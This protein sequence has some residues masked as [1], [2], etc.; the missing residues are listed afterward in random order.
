MRL[1]T[2]RFKNLNSLAGEWQIDFTHTD[3]Q[4]QG[5][6]AIVGATGAGKSTLLDAICL[7]LY[8]QTPRL[9]KITQSSNEIMS[10]HYGECFAEVEFSTLK[11]NYRCHWG[12][13]RAGKKA[14]GK[15]QS[16][17]HEIVAVATGKVLAHKIKTVQETLIEVSGLDFERFTRAILLAQ[18]GFSAFLQAK[19]DERSPIL[20]QLTGTK[21][22]SQI[23]IKVAERRSEAAK[24]LKILET[25][26]AGIQVLSNE[27]EQTKQDQLSASQTQ[28]SHC[29]HQREHLAKAIAWQN[30][31][32]NNR[33]K[34]ARILKDTQQ[35]ADNYQQHK[36][37]LKTLKLAETAYAIQADYK[38][39]NEQRSTLKKDKNTDMTLSA[40]RRSLEDNNQKDKQQRD[41]AKQSHQQRKKQQAD[42][43]PILK[44]VR[45]L[46]TQHQSLLNQSEQ[47]Q[48]QYNQVK[49]H[50][51]KNK[52]KQGDQQ[53]QQSANRAEWKLI[54]DYLEK[55]Q[56]DKQ[57]HRDLSNLQTQLQQ[58][59]DYNQNLVALA[60]EILPLQQAVTENQAILHLLNKTIETGHKQYLDDQQR[61][62]FVQKKLKHNLADHTTSFW[63]QQ[64]KTQEQN[65]TRQAQKIG[66]LAELI[67]LE[68]TI[69]T[70]SQTYQ[71]N[72]QNF[73]KI[74][75]NC[76][77]EK[78]RS[79][80]HYEQLKN[81][82]TLLEEKRSLKKIQSSL[83]EHRNQLHEYEACPL[84][85]STEHPYVKTHPHI[86]TEKTSQQLDHAKQQWQTTQ[87]RYQDLRTQQTASKVQLR[88]D[89]AELDQQQL[90]YQ[91]DIKTHPFKSED[92]I[93]QSAPLQ[94][95]QN[96]ISEKIQQLSDKIEKI[97]GYEQEEKQLHQ[98]L[99]RLNT[100]QREREQQQQKIKLSLSADQIEQRNLAKQSQKIQND[101]Y[102]KLIYLQQQLQDYQIKFEAPYSIQ[103]PIKTLMQR[104][105]QWSQQHEQKIALEQQY[106]HQK[107]QYQH[108]CDEQRKLE[109]QCKQQY[110]DLTQSQQKMAVLKQQRLDLFSQKL[111]DHEEQQCQEQVDKAAKQYEKKRC[112]YEKNLK[113]YY[114][115]QQ[116]Q[117]QLDTSITAQT[118]QLTQQESIFQQ[119]L[120]AHNFT[121]EIAYQKA[122]LS[123]KLWQ[124]YTQIQENLHATQGKLETL[125]QENQEELKRLESENH[126]IQDLS[127]LQR[128]ATEKQQEEAELNQA[129]GAIK[130]ALSQHKQQKKRSSNQESLK[131][132]QT[133]ETRRWDQLHQLIGSSDG[134]KFRNFAQGLTFEIM[135]SY[136]NQQL[137]KMN[138]RYLLLHKDKA[139]LELDVIDKHQ[140]GEIRSIKNLSGGE[141]F[142]VSLALALGLSQMASQNI[143]MDSLFLDEGFGS[144]D[145]DTL[146]TVL[147]ALSKLHQEN[148]IIGIISHVNGL[149]ER[150]VSQIQVIATPQGK[151]HLLGAGITQYGKG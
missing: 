76:E 98:T 100:Q 82:E 28:L 18:G 5:L 44:E 150:I 140:A 80:V 66:K 97:E 133:N 88:H 142:I 4:S 60:A 92:L 34:Y 131:D 89:Q 128:Q 108:L 56:K 87:Q 135:I 15:L 143:Q 79:E 11:G 41:L 9:G 54:N 84:C 32:A 121:D 127:A 86:D 78:N 12:Q 35:L 148:K 64:L 45:K 75:V 46:D 106:S 126:R 145:E 31:Y 37:L 96:D 29:Q 17:Q 52:T 134:K 21:I 33:T 144:L 49:Q 104:Q 8:G 109:Q 119:Q 81:L 74:G 26:L 149:K 129:I 136:A 93:S 91:K 20:E 6:F 107:I 2:L 61:Q 68:K 77:I 58:F 51:A 110:D 73:Q 62:Q 116:Q 113:E 114:A 43:R 14:A 47:Q 124:E 146:E 40:E 138:D 123:E 67:Q 94:Q 72:Q 118:Q 132:K 38:V 27:E 30:Q 120:I 101:K 10:R 102:D 69:R 103:M 105:Q 112:Q 25:K 147:E 24:T 16:P 122:C 117:E 19:P 59:A 42:L 13:H 63:R 1:L 70:A 83:E 71:N 115:K 125:K 3:Y 151:S 39:L 130:Q 48:I 95:Q 50:V 99:A 23:S 53:K 90:Q 139:P 85:G 57:L 22:Y 141:S 111:A 7:A 65:S 36:S 137:Q 55:H